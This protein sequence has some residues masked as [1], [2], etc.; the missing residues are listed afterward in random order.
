MCV[1]MAEKLAR[2]LRSVWAG[3]SS[4]ASTLCAQPVRPAGS[5][6]ARQLPALGV[7]LPDTAVPYW[8]WPGL[9]IQLCMSLLFPFEKALKSA[10]GTVSVGG[11]GWVRVQEPRGHTSTRGS[12]ATLTGSTGPHSPGLG[13]QWKQAGIQAGW[14]FCPACFHFG[15]WPTTPTLGP[16]LCHHLG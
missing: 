13:Q 11:G 14:S 9:R 4:W 15:S 6:S 3:G 7:P 5:G 1:S 10:S 12:V 2:A 8:G 16:G